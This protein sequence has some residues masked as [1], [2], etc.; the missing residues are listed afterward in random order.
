M[1]VMGGCAGMSQPEAAVGVLR[2]MV[3]TTSR[4][5]VAETSIPWLCGKDKVGAWPAQIQK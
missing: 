1:G 2:V 3:V 4:A 5:I